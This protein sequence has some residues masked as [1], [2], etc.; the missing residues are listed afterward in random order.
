MDGLFPGERSEHG[1]KVLRE[2]SGSG[3]GSFAVI[4]YPAGAIC[5]L[6]QM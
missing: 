2:P 3:C 4:E 5:A 6:S 1:G